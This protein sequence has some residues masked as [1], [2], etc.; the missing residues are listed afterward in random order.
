MYRGLAVQAIASHPRPR[1]PRV[2]GTPGRVALPLV[3]SQAFIT[4]NKSRDGTVRPAIDGPGSGYASWLG[5]VLVEL[6]N[7]HIPR[8]TESLKQQNP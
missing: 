8:Q 5:I 4:F 2:P 6:R 1:E 7:L 3:G